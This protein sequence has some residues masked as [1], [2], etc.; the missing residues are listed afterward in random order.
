MPFS[1]IA[2][3][4]YITGD[5]VVGLSK[6]PRI[7]HMHASM[8]QIQEQLTHQIGVTVEEVT[9]A[10]GVAVVIEGKHSCMQM[11]GI[12]TDG[13]MVTS[14]LRGVMLANP[15]AKQEFMS[16]IKLGQ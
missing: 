14:H 5:R 1:F 2:H 7:V 15:A 9:K 8:L 11:R 6:I 3:I 16:I 10:R 12:K 4:G 13:R